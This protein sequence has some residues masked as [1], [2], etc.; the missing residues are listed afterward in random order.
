MLHAMETWSPEKRMLGQ[1]CISSFYFGLFLPGAG[2][3]KLNSRV[4][5]PNQIVSLQDFDQLPDEMT[6][7]NANR[8]TTA[9]ALGGATAST[10]TTST[11]SCSAKTGNGVE[12][13]IKS[14]AVVR[15]STTTTKWPCST[16]SDEQ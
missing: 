16:S 9:R 6:N 10:S 14:A 8:T 7:A 5:I 13:Q 4:V 2:R 15:T 1:L 12:A 11:N 3:E